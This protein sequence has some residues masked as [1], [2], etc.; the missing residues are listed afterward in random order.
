M[1]TVSEL[2]LAARRRPPPEK[3]RAARDPKIAAAHQTT[4]RLHPIA[5]SEP[6]QSKALHVALYCHDALI[7]SALD[8]L[9]ALHPQ[10]RS[11]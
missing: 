8:R 4:R 7:L 6:A 1:S 11:A 3:D 5:R 9:F 10:W 2:A